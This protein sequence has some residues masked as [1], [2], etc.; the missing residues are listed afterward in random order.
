ML[1]A[2]RFGDPKKWCYC[3]RATISLQP[4]FIKR[5]QLLLPP[6]H[7]GPEG[8]SASNRDKAEFDPLPQCKEILRRV[9]KHSRE[10]EEIL[11][12]GTVVHSTDA[13]FHPPLQDVALCTVGSMDVAG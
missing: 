3:L 10:K 8:S 1:T 4:Q 6:L 11:T 9:L 12:A 2:I 5:L 7:C 13:L